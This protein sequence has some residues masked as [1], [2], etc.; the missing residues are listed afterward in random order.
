MNHLSNRGPEANASNRC[1]YDVC[2]GWELVTNALR[3]PL[4]RVFQETATGHG[5]S[6]VPNCHSIKVFIVDSFQYQEVTSGIKKKVVKLSDIL[7]TFFNSSFFPMSTKTLTPD[8]PE[9]VE[10][11]MPCYIPIDTIG[12][13]VSYLHHEHLPALVEQHRGHDVRDGL[14][15]D[16]LVLVAVD[17]RL[18]KR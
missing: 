4:P 1:H 3:A 13:I 14:L 2:V 6:M 12:D 8:G 17:R 10:K 7:C 16:G 18:K 5:E 9:F 15:D 11:K